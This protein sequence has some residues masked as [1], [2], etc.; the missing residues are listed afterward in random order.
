M[1]K[2]EHA[3]GY[4]PNET[5]SQED[6]DEVSDNPPLTDEELSRL[7]PGTE[8]MPAAMGAAFRKRGGRPRAEVR[9][10]PISLR[11]D[12]EVLAAYKAGGPGWQTRMQEVLAKGVRSNNR[13]LKMPS[14]DD[15]AIRKMLSTPLIVSDGG[16][17]N[18]FTNCFNSDGPLAVLKDS[19]N[20]TIN[21]GSAPNA[22]YVVKAL[23]SPNF[24][25]ENLSGKASAEY[26]SPSK[27]GYV[28]G[29]TPP[30]KQGDKMNKSSMFNFVDSP[31]NE[32]KVAISQGFDY[33]V[34]AVRSGGGKYE[35]IIARAPGEKEIDKEVVLA[36]VAAM[37][38]NPP[39]T[40]ADVITSAE[41]SGLMRWLRDNGIDA[42]SF[43]ADRAEYLAS[44]DWSQINLP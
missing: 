22:P 11:V 43:I 32:I 3:P 18:H 28:S 7:R 41:S 34:N 26:G 21:N 35:G 33:V 31:N 16:H 27:K 4:V 2:R 8:G 5:Y 1:T 9:R 44:I 12:P 10:V 14:S 40:A 25:G 19:P 24:R 30:N 42:A 13:R 6:W 15:A 37:Q 17:D 29:W 39:S 20:T 38:T 23:R 36:F